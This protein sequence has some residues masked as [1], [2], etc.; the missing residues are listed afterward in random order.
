MNAIKQQTHFDI[1]FANNYSFYGHIWIQSGKS[2]QS[3]NGE[4]VTVTCVGDGTGL[5]ENSL[6]PLLYGITM[7]TQKPQTL[8]NGVGGGLKWLYSAP[9]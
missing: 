3:P 2:P 4:D 5:V 9:Q 7:D 6:N 8:M 1:K